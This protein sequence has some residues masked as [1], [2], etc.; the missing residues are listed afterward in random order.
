MIICSYK[1]DFM[2]IHTLS[3]KNNLINLP[4]HFKFMTYPSINFLF[5]KI[6]IQIQM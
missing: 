6:D 4:K 2:N 1:H 3:I 5:I